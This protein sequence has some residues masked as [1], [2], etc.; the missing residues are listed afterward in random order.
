MNL[1]HGVYNRFSTPPFLVN[2]M[3]KAGTHLLMKAVGMFPGIRRTKGQ[4]MKRL[5]ERYKGP[6]DAQLHSILLGVGWPRPVAL[7]DVRHALQRIKRGHYAEVHMRFSAELGDLLT[8]LGMKT[9]LILRDPRDVVVSH[10]NY[11]SN[12]PRHFL[13]DVY[14]P[15]SDSER[16]MTS[17]TG[18]EQTVPGGPMLLNID[19]RYQS[20][21]PWLTQSLNYTTHF[22]KLVGPQGGGS[23]KEQ[24]KELENVVQHLG[25]RHDPGDVEG[26]ADGLFGG[27]TTFRK[28][29]IGNWRNHFSAEHKRVFEE[30]A[31]QLLI[32]L[33][34]V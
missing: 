16:I 2:S 3:P 13:Y 28:G 18:I 5:A 4:V 14:Q 11:V 31:G 20:L 25:I 27:T 26:V 34:Y 6:D 29:S 19:E 21:M 9:L 32:D 8:E 22:E 17:I 10:V 24:I 15:L 1:M 7:P 23:R 33:G 30:L 12:N